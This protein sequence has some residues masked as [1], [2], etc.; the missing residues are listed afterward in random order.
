MDSSSDRGLYPAWKDRSVDRATRNPQLGAGD[1]HGEIEFRAAAG[2]Q[3]ISAPGPIDRLDNQVSVSQWD[4]TLWNDALPLQVGTPCQSMEYRDTK[5]A[6]KYFGI[7]IHCHACNMFLS[8]RVSRSDIIN[9][10][11]IYT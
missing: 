3:Q 2:F 11:G 6:V 5:I 9:L 1:S 8:Q 4:V 7:M 10:S